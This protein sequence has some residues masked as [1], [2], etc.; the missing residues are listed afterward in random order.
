MTGTTFIADLL[1]FLDSSNELPRG[2]ILE[3]TLLIDDGYVDSFSI[4]QLLAFIE[5]RTG[6][7]VAIETL[8]LET[9]HTPRII[10][11]TYGH[12]IEVEA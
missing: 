2:T 6:T 8:S 5:E 4:M 12:R 7:A 3:D 9:I 11:E 10:T 1:D